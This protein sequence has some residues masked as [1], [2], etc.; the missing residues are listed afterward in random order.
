MNETYYGKVPSYM[1]CYNSSANFCKGPL[2]KGDNNG[3]VARY[4]VFKTGQCGV[5]FDY[6]EMLYQYMPENKIFLSSIKLILFFCG[7]P[8]LFILLIM[9]RGDHK[10]KQVLSEIQNQMPIAVSISQWLILLIYI[11]L[12]FIPEIIL[13]N[14]NA[15]VFG[16]GFEP[17]DILCML[18][19]VCIHGLLLLS[20][21]YSISFPIQAFS[22]IHLAKCMNINIV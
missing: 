14:Q 6:G 10:I 17:E 18:T 13:T 8:I 16:G 1:G 7:T 22:H 11:L 19:S 3:V 20:I 2:T 4:G 15:L 21:L 5:K 12:D 9:T